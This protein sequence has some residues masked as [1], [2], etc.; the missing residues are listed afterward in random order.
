MTRPPTPSEIA[1]WAERVRDGDSRAL[2]RALSEV[3]NR[4][5]AADALLREL[6]PASRAAWRVGVTGAP[7]A[8]K[9]TLVGA[10]AERLQRRAASPAVVAVDPS[11]PFT[12]GA[13]LG[14]RVRMP[15]APGLFVRSMSARGALGGLAGATADVLTVLA[16][17]GR[18][19]LLIETVGV[20]QAEVDVMHVAPAVALVLTP[21]AGDDVQALKAG[22]MEIAD[23]FVINKADLPGAEQLERRIEAM[24]ELRPESAGPRPP[25][26]RTVA[27]EGVGVDELLGVLERLPRRPSGEARY[28]ERRIRQDLLRRL[29][30]TLV[31]GRLEA[32]ALANAGQSVAEGVLNPYAF[33]EATLEEILLAK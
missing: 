5:P 19:P 23:V 13:L 18:D 31:D 7:G 1:A 33:I 14:D 6:F 27:D 15:S 17:A 4:G 30:E 22:I 21:A 2:A 20:G 8:G 12:G 3:E 24:L 11:S 26:L 29:G 10:L 32:G 25:V 16:A 28:W 9:S